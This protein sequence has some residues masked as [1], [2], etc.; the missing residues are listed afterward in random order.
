MNYEQARTM[1]HDVNARAGGPAA[2]VAV[3]VERYD[4]DLFFV[5]WAI[6]VRGL[7]ESHKLDCGCTD[8]ARLEAHIRGFAQNHL[9]DWAKHEA[10]KPAFNGWAA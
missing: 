2:G 5:I 4:R 6:N 3:T 1:A 8:A 10:K 7:I 9:A